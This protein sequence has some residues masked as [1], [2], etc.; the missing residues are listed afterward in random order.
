MRA[1]VDAWIGDAARVAD[2]FAGIGALSLG[3]PGKLSLFE[4]DKPAVAAVGAAA[5]KLGGNRVRGRA[6]AI[7]SAS[8]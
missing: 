4:S 8:R 6:R 5:R 1:A 2:L 3:R 7:S